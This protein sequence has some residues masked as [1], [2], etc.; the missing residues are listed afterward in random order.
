MNNFFQLR[1]AKHQKKMM[2]Y[3]RYVLN[4][5]FVLVCLF[6]FGG[7][8]F[9]YSNW[10][11]TLT[12]PFQ[13]G[14]II[15]TIFWFI[16]LFFGKF[17]TF[18][19]AADLVFLLPKEKEMHQYLQRAFLYS[20]LFPSLFLG[21]ACG[22]SMPLV[23]VTTGKPFSFYFV[24]LL[25]LWG[26]K[27]SQLQI[28]RVELFRIEEKKL[29]VWKASWYLS[30][31]L[32]LLLTVYGWLW[33]GLLAMLIQLN[34]YFWFLWKNMTYRLD[35]EKMIQKEEQRLHQIYQFINLFTNVPE[36]T[37]KVKRRRYLDPLLQ[38]T[39]K[40]KDNTYYYLYVRRFIRG[41]DFSG[42][43]LRLVLIGSILIAGIEDVYFIT[44]IG[45]LFIYLIG[46]QVIPLYN[47]FR[48]MTLVQLYPITEKQK[49][50]ALQKLLLNLLLIAA[51]LFGLIGAIV[52]NGLDKLIPIISYLIVTGLFIK[53]YTPTRIKKMNE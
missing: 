42:L 6:L 53:I 18:T 23:V 3:L 34:I 31:L 7:V 22:F 5:H 19:Q 50:V 13:M 40:T 32:I 46:F 38:H 30:T 24:Y 9:Y 15:L 41:S 16:C 14:G 51:S 17:A 20:S 33:L 26:L 43:F 25:I 8:G 49:E 44:A 27:S 37:S 48:Y 39:K 2:K 4:D 52:L 10:L 29:M 35:W 36:I 21:L 12:T 28:K 11:K 47:Q 45:A 1:L